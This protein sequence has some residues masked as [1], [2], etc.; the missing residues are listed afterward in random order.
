MSGLGQ[1]EERIA[2]LEAAAES[3]REETREARQAAKDLRRVKAEIEGLLSTEIRELVDAAVAE[4]VEAGLDSYKRALKDSIE[5][6]DVAVQKRFRKLMNMYL[7]GTA[8][9]NGESLAD[10]IARTKRT[11]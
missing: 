1:L 10:V 3:I 9:G 8:S 2:A 4:Q 5:K 6:V 7:T 11:I